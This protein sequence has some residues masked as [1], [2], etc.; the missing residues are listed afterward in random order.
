MIF[1]F[2]GNQSGITKVDVDLGKQLVTVEGNAASDDILQ[3]IAKTG[4]KVTPK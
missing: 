3:A 4:K 2:R 1:F